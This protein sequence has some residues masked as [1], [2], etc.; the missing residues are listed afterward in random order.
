MS[1]TG[2]RPSGYDRL[3]VRVSELEA[4]LAAANAL[5]QELQVRPAAPADVPASVDEVV[6]ADAPH[7]LYESLS[8]WRSVTRVGLSECSGYDN[9]LS[10]R[11]VSA[12]MHAVR[13]GRLHTGP[14]D[15]GLLPEF[16]PRGGFVVKIEYVPPREG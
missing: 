10:R 4:E 13:F 6:C 12:A 2:A 11:I 16:D 3:K 8:P 7:A 5:V 1:D 9:N 15:Y 14:E